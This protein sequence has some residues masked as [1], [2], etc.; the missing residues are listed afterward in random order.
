VVDAQVVDARRYLMRPPEGHD[1]FD[2]F[3]VM[4]R[5]ITP[6]MVRGEPRFADRLLKILA[7]ANGLPLV[8]HNAAFDLGVI[9]AAC[10]VSDLP[11]PAAPTRA[12]S[13]SRA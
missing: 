5:G 2:P 6:A 12:R 8:D 7:F 9:R 3:N 1:D 13:C 4:L 11:W 10:V